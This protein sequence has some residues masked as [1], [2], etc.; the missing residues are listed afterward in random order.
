MGQVKETVSL[1]GDPVYKAALTALAKS[2][3]I[4][5]GALVRTAIDAHFG[6]ELAEYI[7]FF[8]KRVTRSQGTLHER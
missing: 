7:S 6:G 1:Q 5:Q 3:G 8:E 2:K 4:S